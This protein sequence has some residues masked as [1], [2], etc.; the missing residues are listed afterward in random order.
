LHLELARAYQHKSEFL[1]NMSHELRTP[2]SAIIGFSELLLADSKS[3]FDDPTRQKFLAQIS[4]SGQDLLALINDILDLSKVEAGHTVLQIEE[5]DIA[6]VV[7]SVLST[8]EPLAAKKAIRLEANMA[9]PGQVPAD[10]GKLKQM[11]LNLV[12]NA[13]KFTPDGGCVTITSERDAEMVEI[14]V[15]DTGIG[16]AEADQ[17][18]VFEDFRQLDSTIARQQHGTGLGLALTRR[19]AQLHGGHVRLVSELGKG[20]VFTLRLPLLRTGPETLR[21]EPRQVA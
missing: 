2:L 19:Y 21:A 15:R 9:A 7:G 11:L 12:S 8:M 18:E 4:T 20:S 16:I 10:S 1:A 13:V 6:G 17:E 5:V 3:R 14:S